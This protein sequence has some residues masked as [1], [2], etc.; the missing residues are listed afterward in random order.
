MVKNG[1]R[2]IHLCGDNKRFALAQ[3][4]VCFLPMYLFHV[5]T[6]AVFSGHRWLRFAINATQGT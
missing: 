1:D 5:G 4:N 6:L 3:A 2:N